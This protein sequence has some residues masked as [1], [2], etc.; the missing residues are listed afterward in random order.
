MKQRSKDKQSN[1]DKHKPLHK[2][3]VTKTLTI[4]KKVF[5]EESLYPACTSTAIKTTVIY[6][7]LNTTQ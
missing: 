3:P 1:K 5:F 4:I 6:K 7:N 2:L